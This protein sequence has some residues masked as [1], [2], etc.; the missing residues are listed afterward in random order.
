MAFVADNSIIADWVIASQ[1]DAYAG[2]LLDRA[3]T[4]DVHVPAIWQAEF[5]SVLLVFTHYRRL[6]LAQAKSFIEHIEQL[7]LIVDPAQCA[8]R[9]IGAELD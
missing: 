9:R 5:A 2:G 3:A 8:R 1:T 4:E 6:Q 7:E